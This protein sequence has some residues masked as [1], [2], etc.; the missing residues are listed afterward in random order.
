MAALKLSTGSRM[1]PWPGWAWAAK[2][3]GSICMRP[4]GVP[5]GLAPVRLAAAGLRDDSCSAMVRSAGA[6][7]PGAPVR[8]IASAIHPST[9]GPAVPPAP[10]PETAPEGRAARADR[11]WAAKESTAE[12]PAADRGGGGANREQISATR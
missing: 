8:A 1:L 7:D 4:I 11:R 10:A 5:P 9:A 2:V 3:D 6:Q 12:V